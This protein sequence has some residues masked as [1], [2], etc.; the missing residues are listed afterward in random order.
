MKRIIALILLISTLVFA[1]SACGTGSTDTPPEK[2]VSVA[3]L[4]THDDVA[5]MMLTGEIEVAI[6]P[7]PK[8]TASI[9]AA[10]Q[11]GHNYSI[12][13]NLSTEWSGVSDYGLAMGCIAVNN[14]SL[15]EKETEINLFLKDYKASI[16]YINDPANHENSAQLIVDAGILP[17]L[18][19]AKAAL[20][21]L[22]GS[23]VYLDGN[24]MKSTLESFYTAIGMALP[25]D[26]FY[27]TASSTDATPSK[28]LTVGVMNGPTGMGMAKLINDSKDNGLFEFVAYTD[29]S[30]ALTDLNTGEIDMAC[31]PT[32]AVANAHN[33]GMGI[34]ALAINTL[35]SLYVVVKDGVEVN[36]L[37]DLVGKTVYYGVPTSTTEPIFKYILSK[38]QIEVAVTDEE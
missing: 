24:D 6:L 30:V 33:K 36:S 29:P 22:Y 1:L 7:E 37:E 3:P 12:A 27:Y 8:A 15:A 14:K 28:K 4:K 20:E 10:K 2:I 38:K 13:L 9:L 34:S 16:E 18:P 31:L 11:Q 23:I 5:A 32:N 35:G 19:I 21:N 26:S 25:G 17:K